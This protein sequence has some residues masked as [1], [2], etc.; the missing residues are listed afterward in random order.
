MLYTPVAGSHCAF[1]K[2]NIAYSDQLLLFEQSFH[3][4]AVFKY[5]PALRVA[6]IWFRKYFPKMV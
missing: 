5:V 3:Y 6:K 4:L 2:K 1:T